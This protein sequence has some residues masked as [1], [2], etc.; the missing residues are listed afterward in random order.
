MQFVVLGYSSPSKLIQILVPWMKWL[1]LRHLAGKEVRGTQET[2]ARAHVTYTM[3]RDREPVPSSKT[4][5]VPSLA[6]VWEWGVSTHSEHWGS[7]TQWSQEKR[8]CCPHPAQP[9]GLSQ[10]TAGKPLAVAPPCW[11]PV[12]LLLTVILTG[13]WVSW[14]ILVYLGRSHLLEDGKAYVNV[15]SP[16]LKLTLHLIGRSVA[17]AARGAGGCY[18]VKAKGLPVSSYLSPWPQAFPDK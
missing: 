16:L 7:R 17:K 15:G 2:H 10:P 3:G 18:P 9:L 12:S 5:N 4:S 11:T 13:L 1:E 6:R 14:R 8:P